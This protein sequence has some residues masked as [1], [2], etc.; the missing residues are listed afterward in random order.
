MDCSPE[1]GKTGAVYSFSGAKRQLPGAKCKSKSSSYFRGKQGVSGQWG[2]KGRRA[3]GLWGQKLNGVP[4]NRVFSVPFAPTPRFQV[5]K[6]TFP[7]NTKAIGSKCHA[8][9]PS[10]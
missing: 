5:R 3:G 7:T 2:S 6:C 10:A 9:G 1:Q 8:P 4:P